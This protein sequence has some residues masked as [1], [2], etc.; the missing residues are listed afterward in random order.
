M[1][2][3]SESNN[4]YLKGTYPVSTPVYN[5]IVLTDDNSVP[6]AVVS[7]KFTV[8][9]GGYNPSLDKSTTL[10]TTIDGKRDI[11]MG[12]VFWSARYQIRLRDELTSEETAADWGNRLD[13]EYFY[14]LNNPNGDPSNLITVTDHYGVDHTGYL[15]GSHQEQ[16]LTTVIH[17]NQA[18]FIINIEFH[19]KVA[20]A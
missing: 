3:S 10:D 11:T 12:S 5:F 7:R 18:N 9:Q 2:D 17:G 4:A 8:V 20:V 16:P 15:I 14:K 13:L 19:E 1:T 6:E